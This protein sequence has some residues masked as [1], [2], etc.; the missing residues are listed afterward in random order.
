[1]ASYVYRRRSSSLTVGS[2][3]NQ[4]TWTGAR[5]LLVLA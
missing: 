2:L 4:K 5:V 1:M 3:N